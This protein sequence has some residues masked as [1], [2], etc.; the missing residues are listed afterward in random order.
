MVGEISAK[1]GLELE[2]MLRDIGFTQEEIDSAFYELDRYR[3]IPGTT[4]QKY[5]RRI[6]SAVGEE[7]RPALLKGILAGTAIRQAVE[8]AVQEDLEIR[9]EVAREMGFDPER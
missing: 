8:R 2:A 6:L 5:L 1:G 9:E 7:E 4:L 3:E